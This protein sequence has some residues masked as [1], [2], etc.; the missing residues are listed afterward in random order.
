MRVIEQILDLARWAPSGDNTQPWRLEI[1]ADDQALIHGLDTRHDCVYDLEGH[2]SQLAHGALLE[3][4]RI[5]AT[6]HGLRADW[7]R[8]SDTP[9]THLLYDVRLVADPSV[10]PDPLIPCI[11]TRSVQRRPMWGARLS[12]DE[13]SALEAAAHPFKVRWFESF[14]DRLR[15]AR[16]NF[17]NAEVRLTI[18]EAYEVHKRV[19]EW[20]VRF[21][22]DRIPE[23][24]VGVDPL[25]A[26]TMRWVMQSWG[27]VEF[28]NKWFAGTLGPRI[29]LDLIPG[30]ACSAHAC[31]IA[32]EP[33]TSIEHRV[34]AGAAVQRFWLTCEQLGL[35]HQP[36]MTPLI[37]AHYNRAGRSFTESRAAENLSRGL[38]GTL[39]SILGHNQVEKAMWLCRVGRSR[40]S[41]GRSLRKPCGE[42]SDR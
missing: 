38:A 16:L 1:I 34:A 26:K 2:A 9:D 40:S 10:R 8:R 15:I 18:R 42:A 21:S 14:A 23:V 17:A 29:Q 37:F 31:L 3:T 5:A 13:R 28:F 41:P 36:E 30:I 25:T 33:A 7:T 32:P 19:I 39:E 12:A 20:G 24:A 27:R 35:Q 11:E 22:E 6:G 4:L